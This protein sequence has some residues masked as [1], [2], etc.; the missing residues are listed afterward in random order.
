MCTLSYLPKNEGGFILTSNRDESVLR[1][2]ALPPTIYNRKEIRVLYP[3]DPQGGGT[4]LATSATRFTL[5]LLNGAFTRHTP[6]PP[7]RQ[8]RGLVVTD[9]FDFQDA[10]QFVKEY[11]FNGIEPFTLVIIQHLSDIIMHELRWDGNTVFLKKINA[12][13]P[14][15]WSSVT[16]YDAPVIAARKQWF[17]DFLAKN[18]QP[19]WLDMLRFHHFGGAGDT[20]TSLLMNRNNGLCTVS[21]TS[22][23]VNDTKAE[24]LHEDM[25]SSILSDFQL[26]YAPTDANH[27]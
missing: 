12:S 22:I 1:E 6:N 16:L 3:K 5:C 7:Y 15:I 20:N 18:V 24:I 14:Q 9:F 19:T 25:V 10:E 11:S 21:I 23:Q 13:K 17:D 8:S 26:L 4:W 27:Y 2:P